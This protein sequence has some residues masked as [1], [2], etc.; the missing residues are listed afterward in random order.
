[1]AT[2]HNE[3]NKGDIAK[4]IILTGDP[5]RATKIKDILMPD[6]KLVNNIRGMKTYTGT[7]NG[8]KLSIMAHG[9]GCASMGIYAHELFDY[10]DV[11]KAIRI[12]TIGSLKKEISLKS[13]IIA[14]KS[15]TKTNF[16]NYFI[17][18]GASFVDASENM[19]KC[20]ERIFE[21]E[22]IEYYSGTILCSD[23]FYTDENQLEL[24]KK[25][26]LLGVE[27][28]SAALNL[29]A[30]KFNKQALTICNVSDNIATNK[31]ISAKE[32]EDMFENLSKL[33]VQILFE[34]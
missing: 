24:A 10:Y 18:N 3:A 25:Y 9:M 34:E 20:A 6:A 12:G 19:V 2:P 23:N 16:D 11:E 26:D 32:R 1:M 31:S 33:A 29:M 27:M 28:E 22:N 4:R 5:N 15:F 7:I 13:M 14:K 30:Q 17:N 21:K 8:K